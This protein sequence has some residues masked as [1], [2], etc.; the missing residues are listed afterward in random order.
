MTYYGATVIHPKTIR[1]LA[2]KGIPLYVRSFL[3]ADVEGTKIGNF[4]TQPSIPSIIV[5][6]NQSMFVFKA[7]DLAAINERNQLAYI[8]SEL[9]RYNIKINLL[10]VSATSFSVCTDNDDRKLIS[11]KES[12]SNDFELSVLDNLELITVKNYDTETLNNFT[13]L[14]NAL[15]AQRSEDVFQVV[16]KK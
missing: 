9:N 8:H 15:V 6:G 5:K 2:A 13:G 3:N 14:G 12:L 16:V 7:K 11:L 1:P 4:P 10:Q